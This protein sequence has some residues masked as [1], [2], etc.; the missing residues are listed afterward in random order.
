MAERNL[1]HLT[2]HNPDAGL[3][4]ALRNTLLSNRDAGR[5]CSDYLAG[6]VPSAIRTAAADGR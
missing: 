2:G 3:I 4:M 1:H 6:N 5:W